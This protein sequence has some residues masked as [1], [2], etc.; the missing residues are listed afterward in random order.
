MG[1]CRPPSDTDPQTTPRQL[2]WCKTLSSGPLICAGRP[3]KTRSG[4]QQTP[5]PKRTGVDDEGLVLREI[6]ADGAHHDHGDDARHDNHDHAGVQDAEPVHLRCQLGGISIAKHVLAAKGAAAAAGV[7]QQ[8]G[9]IATARYTGCAMYV[10]PAPKARELL[11]QP[12]RHCLAA[13]TARQAAGMGASA[14]PGRLACAGRRPTATTT[15]CRSPP[16][17]RRTCTRSWRLDRGKDCDNQIGSKEMRTDVR[18]S[19][20]LTRL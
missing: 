16:S 1:V 7:E 18:H 15:L 13:G 5:W 9:H 19:L 17:T 12:C 10:P 3:C 14:A 6:L 8:A 20:R 4:Q 2:R 11:Q